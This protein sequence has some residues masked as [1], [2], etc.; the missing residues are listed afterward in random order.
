MSKGDIFFIAFVIGMIVGSLCSFMIIGISQDNSIILE[1]VEDTYRNK[2]LYYIDKDNDKT[3][4]IE[5][6]ILYYQDE[7][8]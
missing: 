3:Y 5:N 8:E 2:I 4:N 6:G 1:P 7:R